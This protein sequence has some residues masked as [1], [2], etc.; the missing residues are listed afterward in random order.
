MKFSLDDGFYLW[1]LSLPQEQVEWPVF[2]TAFFGED[3]SSS[4]LTPVP[5][6]ALDATLAS[7]IHN[8]HALHLSPSKTGSKTYDETFDVDFAWIDQGYNFMVGQV[9]FALFGAGIQIENMAICS[10]V[11]DVT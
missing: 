3:N 1:A 4:T 7:I 10:Y 9:A 11:V 5:E 8:L 2:D 6:A